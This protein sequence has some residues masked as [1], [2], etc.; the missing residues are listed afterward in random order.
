[1]TALNLGEREYYLSEARM[2]AR[3]DEL[4]ALGI[5]CRYRYWRSVSFDAADTVDGAER[6]NPGD[7]SVVRVSALYSIE[8]KTDLFVD[9]EDPTS[10]LRYADLDTS[11]K[12][13]TVLRPKRRGE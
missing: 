7:P 6:L 5:K 13:P 2:I 12:S 8:V 4:N 11:P 3:R 10:E 9:P 1:M